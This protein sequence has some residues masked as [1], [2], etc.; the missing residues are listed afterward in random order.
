MAPSHRGRGLGRA[1]LQP[2]LDRADAD[3]VPCYLET[4]QPTNVTFYE[5]LGFRVLVH[6]VEPSSGLPLWTFRRDPSPR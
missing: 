4:A 5:R 3:G 1:L 6:V 2:V